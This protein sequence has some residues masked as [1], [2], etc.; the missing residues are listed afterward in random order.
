MKKSVVSFVLVSALYSQFTVAS[1]PSQLEHKERLEEQVLVSSSGVATPIRQVG[2][3]V[4]II[5]HEDI[6]LRGY[7]SLSEILR[8]QV[9][10]AASNSGGRGKATA[11]RIRGEEGFRTLVKIDGVDIS[12]PTGVQ[13]GPQIQHLLASDDIEKVEVL[14]GPQGFIYG[15]DAG[16]VINIFTR[17][18]K[19]QAQ[20]KVS[21]EYGRFDSTALNAYITSGNDVGDI[22]VAIT[23]QRSEG[24]NTSETDLSN[25]NDGYDNTTLHTKL[26]WNIQPSWRAQLVVRNVEAENEFDN[27]SFRD[28][29][30]S[31]VGTNQCLGEFDQLTARGSLA[32]TGEAMSHSLA[33]S[34]TDIERNN[35]AL[36]SINTFAT[37]GGIDKLEYLGR[38]DLADQL[39]LVVGSD[40]QSQSIDTGTSQDRDQLGVFGEV[41]LALADSVFVTAG[42]RHDDN[43]DF[44]EH[45][46]VRLSGAYIY[47]LNADAYLKA[48]SSYG[49]GFR[50]PSLFE[51][52]YNASDN[53]FGE[54]AATVLKE[55]NSA[56]Y[57]VAFEYH[58]SALGL[59]FELT[60]FDQQVEDEIFFDN[61][62]F[63]GYLQ[64]DGKTVSEG[65]E[66]ATEYNVLPIL[67]IVANYTY[68]D[69]EL[70]ERNQMAASG[71]TI[72]NI[73][74]RRRP[75]NIANVGLNFSLLENKLNLLFNLRSSRNAIERNGDT[76]VAL[77]DYE[78]L[79]VSARYRITNNLVI[80][81]RVEN[82]N[83]EDYREVL[84]F[85]TSGSAVYAGIKYQF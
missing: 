57:D 12:D 79:D 51:V 10:I 47:T 32:Y 46:S 52:S 71:D 38:L 65:I 41:Q 8:T 80:N 39:T 3:S 76:V 2:T 9:G 75:Q 28:S 34:Y 27:C 7:Q 6:A 53:A 49:T 60:Y 61:S 18:G 31:F 82:A 25:D 14:R 55:E 58:N 33:Y 48:R 19:Q 70:A 37:E 59:S 74:R 56:G 40:F 21:A 11:L 36:G 84:G 4:S 81:A 50:A 85:N 67:A 44:G 29:S 63:S 30:G 73:Q 66:F 77:D 45:T 5:T 24:F 42:A 1:G 64:D 17:S 43:D 16:G 22:F 13:I 78:V 20:G 35:I 15:A 54:A 69:T 26:G 68:N 62:A 83:D 23:D 72:T